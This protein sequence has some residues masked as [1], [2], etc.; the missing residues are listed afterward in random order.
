MDRLSVTEG[1]LY[2]TVAIKQG[3]NVGWV[4]GEIEVLRD[5]LLGAQII[6]RQHTKEGLKLT[7]CKSNLFGY[8]QY[9]LAP[10]P[11]TASLNTIRQY[12]NNKVKW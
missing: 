2:I 4:G 1:A 12:H 10:I 3:R 8:N 5:A 11:P 9:L 7:Q 6:E